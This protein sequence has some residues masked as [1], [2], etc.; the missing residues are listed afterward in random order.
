MTAMSEPA[1][2]DPDA[3]EVGA[4]RLLR[5][6]TADGVQ[7][8][9]LDGTF[10]DGGFRLVPVADWESLPEDVRSTVEHGESHP[11]SWVRRPRRAG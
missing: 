9:Y 3:Y 4:D 7:T 11:E 8:Y 1:A 10:D 5:L 2:G 6:R